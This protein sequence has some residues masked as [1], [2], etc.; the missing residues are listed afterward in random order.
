MNASDILVLG[1]P[2]RT[3]G[4]LPHYRVVDAGA[5]V[6]F[7]SATDTWTATGADGQHLRGRIL[8]DARESGDDTVATHGFPNQFR[9]AGPHTARQARYVSRIL[10]AVARSDATRIEARSRIRVHPLL[11]TRGLSRF[12]L[13]GS[14]A[15][16]GPADETYDGP[17]VVTHD[18]RTYDSRV[19]LTGHFD[20]IDGHY[21]WQGTL[22]ADLPGA[23]VTGSAVDIRIGAHTAAARIS[24]QTPWGTLAVVG[25]AG[26]PPFPLED[27]EIVLPPDLSRTDD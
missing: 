26:Y 22:Y 8:I 13:D 21:H 3:F 18:G 2:A 6:H 14:T 1:D 24:E 10:D 9:I 12:Y 19:R 4:R 17:A 16:T 7:D 20:P 25:A 23:R 5:A 15:D 27:V 11:P